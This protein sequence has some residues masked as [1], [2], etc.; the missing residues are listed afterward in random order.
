MPTLEKGE[1]MKGKQEALYICPNWKK[2]KIKNLCREH[3]LP[4]E[5]YKDCDIR[6]EGE[7]CPACIPVKEPT[8]KQEGKEDKTIKIKPSCIPVSLEEKKL[9]EK[10]VKEDKVDVRNEVQ[11]LRSNISGSTGEVTEDDLIRIAK[12]II[13]LKQTIRKE[14]IEEI[15]PKI[16][17]LME[18]NEGIGVIALLESELK[19]GK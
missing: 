1:K 9:L 7:Q 10:F 14:V 5:K 6:E 12:E 17:Y 15:L 11:W 13:Q 19:E 4:H 18:K 8:K 16:K 3:Y 2:C